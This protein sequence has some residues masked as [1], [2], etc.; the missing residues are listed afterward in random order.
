ME[1]KQ[2]SIAFDQEEIKH[3]KVCNK[4]ILSLSFMLKILNQCHVLENDMKRATL[5]SFLKYVVRS[6]HHLYFRN[7]L[8]L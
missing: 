5:S 2:F 8:V 6:N 4:K 1:Q 7:S 3:L